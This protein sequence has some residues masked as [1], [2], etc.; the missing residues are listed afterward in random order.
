MSSERFTDAL[1]RKLT[2]R[3]TLSKFGSGAVVAVAAALGF[4]QSSSAAPAC[5]LCLNVSSNCIT[6]CRDRG[7]YL[8]SWDEGC[9]RCYECF[10]RPSVTGDCHNCV[11]IFCSTRRGICL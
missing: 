8:Y 1:G 7:Y 11:N 3:R 5:R 4:A 6:R 10:K 2:R 9:Y